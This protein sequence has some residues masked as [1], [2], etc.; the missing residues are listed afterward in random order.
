MIGVGGTDQE[1]LWVLR[2]QQGDEEAFSQIVEAYQRPVYNLAY[3][4]LGSAGD[5]QDAA[6]EVFLRAYSHLESYD[7]A[8]KF[9]S[10]ILSIA[11][12]Y[13]IDRLRRGHRRQVSLDEFEPDRWLPDTAPRPEDEAMDRDQEV[14]IRRLLDVLPEQHRLV[15]VLRYWYDMSYQEI[16]QITS[17]TESAVKSRLHR[18]RGAMAVALQAE[19]SIQLAG[20]EEA[21][22]EHAISEAI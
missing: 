3:R 20:S 17:S 2:A 12:H 8:R 15:I 10:W 6:Q 7:P 4:M 13:C 19:A 5:A 1:R 18:A 21:I 22:G 16:A 11:S 9:S 14:R